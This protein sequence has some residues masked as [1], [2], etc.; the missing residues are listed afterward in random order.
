MSDIPGWVAVGVTILIAA[1]SFIASYA[2]TRTQVANVRDRMDD[3]DERHEAL[4]DEVAD[5]AKDYVRRND[6]K[7]ALYEVEARVTKA[8]DEVKHE[9]R[10][11]AAKTIGEF[12]E[13]VRDLVGRPTRP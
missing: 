6:L 3:Q 4:R 12:K 10:D 9:V 8:V 7:E 2:A 13:M 1:A 11:A 5:I